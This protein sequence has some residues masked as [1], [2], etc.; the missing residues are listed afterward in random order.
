MNQKFNFLIV[1][2]SLI[3]IEGLR[4]LLI[5]KEYTGEVSSARD[6]LSAFE[7]LNRRHVD[8]VIL[9]L[10]FETKEFNGFTIAK[11][12]RK[13]YPEL[14]VLVLSEHVRVFIYFKLFDECDVHAYLDK[15]LGFEQLE[16]A[17]KAISSGKKYI[18]PNIEKMIKLGARMKISK[19]EKEVVPFLLEGYTQKE[20]GDKLFI[21][22]KTVEKHIE[23]MANK[24]GVKRTVPVV[25]KYLRYIFSH[26][27]NS[28]GGMFPLE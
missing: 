13:S 8:M 3:F 11:K 25:V 27:E 4:S 17:I 19:R 15:Q 12:I 28:D 21:S 9:D 20:I 26:R 22:K 6:V 7:I 23:N 2:D 24:L 14:K 10:N 18:D 1:E 5:S 16:K